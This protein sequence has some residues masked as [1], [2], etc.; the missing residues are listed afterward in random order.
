MKGTIYQRGKM[1]W[2]AWYEQVKDPATGKIRRKQRYCSSGSERKNDAVSLLN[3]KLYESRHQ[4][5]RLD[6]PDPTY[7][8]VRDTWLRHR[9]SKTIPYRLKNGDVYFAG[10]KHLDAYF[11]GWQAKSI[12][13][14]DIEQFQKLLRLKGLGNGIDRAVAALRAMLRHAVSTGRLHP[15]QLP[16]RFPMLRCE[17]KAPQPIPDKFFQPL[18]D[19]LPESYRVPFVLAYHTGMR[20]SEVER[21]RWEHVHLSQKHLY[22]PGAKTGRWRK[23]PLLADTGKLLAGLK[24]TK[25][26]DLVFPAMADRTASAR[27]WRTAG[28]AVGCGSWHCRKC[29]ATLT[30]LVCLEH[31]ELNE[32]QARYVG[33]LFRHTR[34]TAIRHLTNLGVPV[35][36][37]MQMMGHENLSIHMGY[38]VADDSD[39]SLI[40]EAYERR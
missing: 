33:P 18:R 34:T 19:A 15:Q 11:Q 30:K 38:N 14:D 16:R 10:R 27:A 12:D 8:D 29:D 39:L 24:H 9:E 31:G 28:V 25:P 36:R 6:L 5:P 23:V 3:T 22:F 35:P 26:T 2:V 32:R 37:I 1:W 20:L 17:R 7:E 40:H 13:T 21:L 4:K